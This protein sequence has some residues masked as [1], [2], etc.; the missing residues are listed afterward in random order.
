MKEIFV[1]VESNS[2]KLDFSCNFFKYF[3]DFFV[4]DSN[5]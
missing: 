5:S 1:K 3:I 2:R 4:P